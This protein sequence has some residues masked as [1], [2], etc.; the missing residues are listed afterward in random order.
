MPHTAAAATPSSPLAPD[1][2]P[3]HPAQML[4]HI[5]LSPSDML[6]A[7]SLAMT[8]QRIQ[9]ACLQ[10]QQQH[11]RGAGE[12]DEG[13][14]RDG[15]SASAVGAADGGGG[16]GGAIQ[17]SE[18]SPDRTASACS[19]DEL[20]SRSAH[21]L[22]AGLLG[23][24]LG[25]SSSKPSPRLPGGGLE[26][27]VPSRPVGTN[28]AVGAGKTGEGAQGQPLWGDSK[29]GE[30]GT[31]DAG[32]VAGGA[33]GGAATACTDVMLCF[34]ATATPPHQL[35][36]SPAAAAFPPWAA[37]TLTEAAWA[38]KYAFASY[39]LLLF[40]FAQPACVC[41]APSAVLLAHGLLAEGLLH[42]GAPHCAAAPR[43]CE[44]PP[45][46]RPPLLFVLPRPCRS[47]G[48]L[49]VCCGRNCGLL[50]GTAQGR[51]HRKKVDLRLVHNLN[52]EATQQACC[53]RGQRWGFECGCLLQE[54]RSSPAAWGSPL[55]PPAS[56]PTRPRLP[57]CRPQGWRT[58]TCWMCGTR[59]SGSTYCP[60]S[61]PWM[62]A[63]SRWWW[64]FGV[65]A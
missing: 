4:S 17:L 44:P 46:L 42:H 29:A 1:S 43:A 27:F 10:Q 56:P 57:P 23:H 38:M 9:R 20:L 33:Q 61:S 50:V 8:L 14:A 49:Q 48:C 55:P 26:S 13:A 60:T 34:V 7:F 28:L 45:T 62:S 2:P 37:E 32:T 15:G 6:A 30:M 25:P 3:P 22:E 24:R 35:C 63:R 51:R 5:D 16:G 40:I 59:A 11:E 54:L 12:G 41:N 64:P 31:V 47:T 39:G 19:V 21:D 53:G 52:R 36:A 58:A 65:R 18:G